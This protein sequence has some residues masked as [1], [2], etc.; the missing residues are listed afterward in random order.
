MKKRGFTLIELL[1]VIVELSVIAL[2][3]TPLI[4]G[5]I[6][7]AKKGA[8]K[9]SVYGLIEST[10]IYIAEN[11]DAGNI[12]FICNGKDCITEDGNK[13]SFK[14]NVPKSGTIKAEEQ[15]IE[16]EYITDG[17][18][19][20]YGTLE[21]LIIDKGCANIDITK[22]EIDES[23]LLIS[24]TTS[25][26]SIRILEGFAI[27]PESGIK[28]Y[29]VTLN[30]E[31]KTLKEIGSL[32]F[33]GLEKNKSY[34]I[35]IEVEN[36]K[37]LIAEVEKEGSTLDFE[38]PTITLTN[39]PTTAVNGY[40]KSQ[41]AKVTYNST[42]ITG[43]KYY[44]KTT[45]TGI[46]SLTVTQECGT[47]TTPST[48]NNITDTTTLSANTWYQVSGNVNVTYSTASSETAT[49]Y[50][51]S[52]D[53]TDYSGAGTATISK[54][55]TTGPTVTLGSPSIK[56]DS[57]TIPITT[58]DSE[59]GVNEVTCKYGT[60]SGNY[61][62]N[63]SSVST[64]ECSIKGLT[65]NT[66]YYYQICVSDKVGNNTCKTGN[67]NT[68]SVTNPTITLTNTPTT[69]V[70][71][72]LKSQVAKVTYNSTN[73][74]SPRYFIKTT[75]TGISSVA[76]TKT[77]GTGTAP[78]TC[79]SVTSTT[80]LSAN[81]WYQVSGNVNVTYSTASSATATIY[82]SIYDGTNYRASTA[83][84]SKIDTTAPSVPSIQYNGGS[85]TCSWK[86]N[87]NITLGSTDG[88]T[89]INHYEID[90]SGDGVSNYT[91]TGSNFI[92]WNG[93]N[94]HNVRFRAVNGLGIAS[95]WTT[96]QHI[97]M[98]TTSPTITFP[99]T[100]TNNQN[101]NNIYSVTYGASGGSI[102]CQNVTF[103]NNSVTTFASMK[104]L[105][106]STVK[107]T[108]VSNSGNVTTKSVDIT[109]TGVFNASDTWLGVTNGAYRNNGT[110]ILP[111][112][113]SSGYHPPF[114]YGPYL[115]VTPGCYHVFYYGNNLN[116]SPSGYDVVQTISGVQQ[117]LPIYSLNY[118]SS[119]SNYNFKVTNNIN[120]LELRLRNLSS[121][122]IS[123]TKITVDPAPSSWCS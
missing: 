101:T 71:G 117:A 80:T 29:R 16:V 7:K 67:N 111:A 62:T 37:G 13:L 28:E 108:A 61:T 99:T 79:T 56:T 26:I 95:D 87:Y 36:G 88:E 20:A 17:T 49:I 74:S 77:C 89:G 116:A 43:I 106:T 52:Y 84:I 103:N 93:F 92:P 75:R 14:G 105:G 46:S 86:N 96:V 113:T 118:V 27:D 65:V 9:N 18:Y 98:D 12:S 47:G 35:K 41:V 73:I 54:I 59:S 120:N 76:V 104:A 19:C 34:S 31:T 51:I 78:S 10:N 121:S 8:F 91:V 39:T 50:A 5:V 11:L 58:S 57:I 90:W 100:S 55:D 1:A 70:N 112:D 107:C 45:R 69:A 66:T 82:A 40:L 122:V 2:I 24:S 3:T 32:T 97:H 53:G 94:S 72:Y 38:N 114:Q 109:L 81:T 68:A 25:S 123:V 21:D 83:T 60:T 48:C 42:N 119:D 102:S 23:K 15:H 22:P 33:E 6:E 85:N 64:T 110:I 44:V 115:N 30:G 63:A 4:I